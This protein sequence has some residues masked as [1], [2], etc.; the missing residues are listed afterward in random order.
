MLARQ[1]GP[2]KAAGPVIADGIYDLPEGKIAAVATYL[3]MRT[4]PAGNSAAMPAGARFERLAGDLP[5]YRRLYGEVGRDWLWFSRA[6]LSDRDLAAII[7]DPDVEAVALVEDGRDIGFVELDFRRAGEC[8]VAFLGLVRD[9]IGR[10]RGDVLAGEAIR[11]AFGRPIR[12]LWLH[13]CTLDH[14][15]ALRFYLRTGFR[16]YRRAVEVAS[17]PRLSGPLPYESAPGFPVV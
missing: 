17:D 1:R 14:P 9:A 13:T 2:A 5:R 15:G 16:P 6:L 4:R 10:R 11:L 3:E 12:R 8:E 7:D